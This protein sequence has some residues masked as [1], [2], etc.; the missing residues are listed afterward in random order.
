MQQN[1]EQQW[2]DALSGILQ[3]FE[4][5]TIPE[6]IALAM[7]PTV[8]IP[9]AKWSLLNRLLMVL[10]VTWDARGYNQ[11]K[12]VGRHVK[13]GARAIRILAPR[14]IKAKAKQLPDQTE[15][16]EQDPGATPDISERK[17]LAGFLFIPVFRYEDTEGEP[18]TYESLELPNLPLLEVARA[19]G[20]QVNA[21]PGNIGMAGGFYGCFSPARGEISLASPEEKV[22]F[23]E[24]AHAAHDRAGLLKERARWQREMVAELVAAVLCR[25]CGR[26]LDENLGESFGYLESQ[27]EKAGLPVSQACLSVLSDVETTLKLVFSEAQGLGAAHDSE[28]LR[29]VA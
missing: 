6:A 29:E 10:S 19:W 14:I 3:E 26:Q 22:F 8:D 4:Q 23:H 24:L 15:A 20:L 2:Q 16:S 27:A 21:I 1:K 5:G 25:V 9:S 7:F 18:L 11:W 13:K 12:Q 28:G 17:R